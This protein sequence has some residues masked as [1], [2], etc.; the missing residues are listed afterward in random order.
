MGKHCSQ[1][2]PIVHWSIYRSGRFNVEKDSDVTWTRAWL[3]SLLLLPCSCWISDPLSEPRMGNGK[4]KR[5]FVL[6]L[7]L[8]TL[9]LGQYS[10]FVE[11]SDWK[12]KEKEFFLIKNLFFSFFFYCRL[13]SCLVP[14]SR[15][16]SRARNRSQNCRTVREVA[17]RQHTQWSEEDGSSGK[18]FVSRK[19]KGDVNPWLSGNLK[20]VHLVDKT[21]ERT[22]GKPIF[23]N[24]RKSSKNGNLWISNLQDQYEDNNSPLNKKLAEY[25]K[26]GNEKQHETSS[27]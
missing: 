19:R 15:S 17:A 4:L 18:N 24:I 14:Q 3:L 27:K 13:N 25:T 12:R 7:G 23:C 10:L 2:Y 8:T 6:G 9:I 11:Y 21:R 26:Q 20:T 16:I 5:L 22:S 1:K